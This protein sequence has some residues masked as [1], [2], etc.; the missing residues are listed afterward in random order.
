MLEQLQKVL[1]LIMEKRMTHGVN[2]QATLNV[3]DAEL[4]WLGGIIDGEGTVVLYV[5]I[6]KDQ[7]LYGAYPQ[8]TIGNTEKVMIDKVADI[9]NR[10]GIGV[11]VSHR[12]PKGPCGVPGNVKSK[13]K[14]LHLASVVGYKRAGK[15]LEVIAP[16]LVTSKKER[17]ELMIEYIRSRSDRIYQGGVRQSSRNFPYTTDDLQMILKIMKMGN[18]KHIPLIERVLRDYTQGRRKAAPD[19]IVR[20]SAKSEEVDLA[21]IPP[22]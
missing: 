2:Q 15:L 18:S 4:G 14:T 12:E 19:D 5:S 17:A 7:K 9:I 21:I 11:H 3:D 22:S 16:Y 1:L 6:T 20:P 10:L 13:Y 8:V